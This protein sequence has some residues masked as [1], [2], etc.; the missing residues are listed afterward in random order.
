MPRDHAE[1]TLADGRSMTGTVRARDP[2]NDLALLAVE[3]GDLPEIQVGDARS[4]RPGALVL[5]VGHPFGVRG[6][7]TI[8]VVHRPLPAGGWQ[9]GANGRRELVQ[10]DLLLGPGNSGGPL[11]DA[12]GQVVG[13]NAM[14]HDGLALAVP[15]HL[16]AR[17]VEHPHGP[18]VLGV[19]VHE[20]ALPP[21]Q[22]EAAAPRGGVPESAILVVEVEPGSAAAEAGVLVGDVMLALDGQPLSGAP[23]LPAALA[24]YRHGG[25][26]LTL[27][28]GTTSHE[29]IVHPRPRAG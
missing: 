22:A 12:R 2:H 15:S 25:A 7:L 18:P 29:V 10:A 24:S 17:L 16:V 27:L 13:I 11:T 3:A 5:A 14:V 6:A 21:L 4:L 23:S 8:G 9:F 1:V 19:T 20:V 26:R 28:R